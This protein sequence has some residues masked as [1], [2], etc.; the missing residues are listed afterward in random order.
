MN[1]KIIKLMSVALTVTLLWQSAA[2]A[3]V[4]SLRPIA[5]AQRE[6]IAC[7]DKLAEPIS[8]NRQAN[9]LIVKKR[10]EEA[11]VLLLAALAIDPCDI[12]TLGI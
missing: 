12:Y 11:K 4:D 7:S 3:E 8:L 5:A 6:R 9:R 2:R 1:H 10:Y